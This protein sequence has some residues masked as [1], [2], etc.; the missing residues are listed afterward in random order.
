MLQKRKAPLIEE[1]LNIDYGRDVPSQRD[2][3]ASVLIV[4]VLVGAIGF[5]AVYNRALFASKIAQLVDALF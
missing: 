5:V 2:A 3:G 4:I 1:L